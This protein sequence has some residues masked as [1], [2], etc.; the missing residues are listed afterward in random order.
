MIETERLTRTYGQVKA[1]REVTLWIDHGVFGLLGP[2]G[3]G[4][5]TFIRILATLLAPTAGTAKVF[6]HDVVRDRVPIRRMLGYLPQ[7]F[8]AYPKLTGREYLHYIAALKDLRRPHSQIEALLEQFGLVE[9]ARRRVTAYS[10]GMLRRLGIAQALLGEPKVLLVDEPT[11][12]LDPEERVRFR[13]HLMGL[14]RDRVVILSTHLVEDVAMI[15]DRLAVLHRGEIRFCGSPSELMEKFAG[16]VYEFEVPET[17]IKETLTDL[18]ARVLTTHR[19][20]AGRAIRVLGRVPGA[21]PVPPSLEDA[22][23]AL[24]RS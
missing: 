11:A 8:G 20:G 9:V 24:I 16:Q 1:L 5:T 21:H 10:G 2:N 6:G 17:S 12:A 7:E 15:C 13:E 18:G 19:R 4:K 22:Y 23:L 3:A 14:G